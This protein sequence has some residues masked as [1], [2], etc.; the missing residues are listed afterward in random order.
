[1]TYADAFEFAKVA[2][3]V[4]GQTVYVIHYP[5]GTDE[6]EERAYEWGGERA[7]TVLFPGGKIVATL[8]PVTLDLTAPVPPRA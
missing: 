5:Q 7:R 4:S 1:M 3:V 2:C 8:V 6:P